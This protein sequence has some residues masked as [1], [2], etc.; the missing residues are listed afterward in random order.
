MFVVIDS[1]ELRRVFEDLSPIL[2]GAKDGATLGFAVENHV[3]SITYKGGLVYERRFACEEAGPVYI[4][5]LYRDIAAFLPSKELVTIYFADNHVEIKTSNFSTILV[6]AYGETMPYKERNKDFKPCDAEMYEMLTKSFSE[7]SPVS[8]TLKYESSILLLPPRAICKYATVWLE[9][10]FKGYSTSIGLR[11]LKAVANF[12]PKRYS[13]S[14][15]VVEFQNGS[16]IL[17]VPCNNVGTIKTCKDII[18]NPQSPIPIPVIPVTAEVQAF[19]R[20]VSGECSVTFYTDG[21]KLSYSSNTFSLSRTLGLCEG[22][23]IYTL[24]TFAEYLPMIFRLL[25]GKEAQFIKA[26]NA[27]MFEVPNQLRLLHSIV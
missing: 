22:E 2:R 3:F 21:Y 26:D 7:L 27:V 19:S 4:T 18:R 10:P 20:A 14:E 15:G 12:Q 8:K 23:V 17:A 5:V 24:D 25:D 11:E 16:A 13:V 1:L 6:Q 9:V